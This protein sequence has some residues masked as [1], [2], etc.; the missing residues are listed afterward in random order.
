[1]TLLKELIQEDEE[2]IDALPLMEALEEAVRTMQ[3]QKRGG[4]MK[5][6]S[7]FVSKN[8]GLA[9]GAA[10][11]A[12]AGFQQYQ[13]NKRNQIR[14]HGKTAQE[15]KMMSDVVANLQ[16]GGQFKIHRIKYE[17]GGKTWILHRKWKS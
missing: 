15:K 1:M 8:P 4:V 10:A 3:M 12:V 16:K 11:L 2:Q 13:K 14:L 5:G 9:V 6:V 7:D 17:G